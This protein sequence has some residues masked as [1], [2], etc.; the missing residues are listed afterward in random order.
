MPQELTYVIT[1]GCGFLGSHLVRMLVERKEHIRELRVVDKKVRDFPTLDDKS[2]DKLRVYEADIRS[3]ERMLAICSGA[4]VIIHAASLIDFPDGTYTQEELWDVN[5]RGTENLLNCCLETNVRC[6]VYTS[7]VDAFGPNWRG[8][9]LEDGDE[10]S[11]Y[12]RSRL[13]SAYGTSKMAAERLVQEMKGRTTK[14]GGKL[15]TCALRPP[16]IYGEGSTLDLSFIEVAKRGARISKP[17]VKARQVYVGNVALAHLLAA[18]KLA[19][20]DGIAYDPVYNIHD[21]TPITNYQEFFEYLSPDVKIQE[22]MVLPLWLLFFIAR[23]F[24]SVRFLLKPFCNFV[25]PVSRNVL[26]NCNTTF[27]LNCAKARRDLGYSPLYTWEQS[28]QRTVDW[29]ES[30]LAG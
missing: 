28:R 14:N 10:E 18:E 25:P 16:H 6:F 5:V 15:H 7:S 23:V 11:P 26:L 27:Y 2:K 17:D 29:I 19:S 22:R 3:R 20:P 13:S 1:G 12:D 4:D 30:Q 9:P 21:D 8:D 24:A